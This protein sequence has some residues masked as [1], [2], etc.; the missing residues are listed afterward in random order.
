MPPTAAES[1]RPDPTDLVIA[2]CIVAISLLTAALAGDDP[3][4]EAPDA[5]WQWALVVVP[6]V[7]VAWRRAAPLV[8]APFVVVGQMAIWAV[9]IAEVFAAPL[10]LIYTLA[11]FGD[12]RRRDVAIVC[13]VVLSATALVGAF[14]APDVGVD[15]FGLTVLSCATAIVLGGHVAQQRA[16]ASALAADLAVARLTQE[17][18]RERAVLEERARIARELH[19]LVGHSLSMIA[20]RA[21]AGE[22]VAASKPDAALETVQAIGATARSSLSEVRRVLSALPAEATGTTSGGVDLA[23]VPGLVDLATLVAETTAASGRQIELTVGDEVAGVADRAVG[24]G[25]YRIVQEALT[26]VIKH[27]GPAA[28]ASVS[29]DRHRDTLVVS[30]TD[31]GLG[32]RHA[33][34]GPAGGAGI[35]GMQ[36]R[37]LVLGGELVAEPDP[38]GG[39]R[40]VARL[41]V[42][43]G[44]S[45][46][47]R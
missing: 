30:I 22:R 39:F 19:D 16:E 23:P 5:W 4:A 24:S 31:D 2:G 38:A 14:R 45:G 15:T 28:S 37:A 9:D 6:A 43:P 21:E 8:C 27:A 11:A 17:T 34:G 7:A 29:V 20:V 35:T 36:E 33:G 41:P 1:R 47:N 18:E 44:L 26:N 32:S 3:G 46:A 12:R 13:G 40:V 42:H 10:V 25:V